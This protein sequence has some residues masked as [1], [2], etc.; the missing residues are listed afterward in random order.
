MR[1]EALERS[2]DPG[3]RLLSDPISDLS[4]RIGEIAV[5]VRNNLELGKRVTKIEW[6]LL[7]CL[8]CIAERAGRCT[9]D[10]L[11]WQRLL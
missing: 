2:V 3:F 6:R 1:T 8:N 10:K 5:Q 4:D 11:E 7:D 9:Q